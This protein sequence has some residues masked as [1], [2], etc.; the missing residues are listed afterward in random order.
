MENRQEN[1]YRCFILAQHS[2]FCFLSRHVWQILNK[3][4]DSKG[5][6]LSNLHSRPNSTYKI[7]KVWQHGSNASLYF[8]PMTW[9]QEIQV[10]LCIVKNKS[11]ITLDHS[12][13]SKE[14][15][16]L[17]PLHQEIAQ[18]VDGQPDVT[19]KQKNISPMY[20]VFKQGEIFKSVQFLSLSS[21]RSSSF[22]NIKKHIFL[23]PPKR[24]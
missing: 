1:K 19:I 9:I 6:S 11:L 15:S 10:F 20:T 5:K 17:V 7:T 14:T 23:T 3:L 22:T 8:Q 4:V 21:G 12:V 24:F 2:G 13:L 18:D 16:L